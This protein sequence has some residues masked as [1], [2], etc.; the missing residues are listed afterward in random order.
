[1]KVTYSLLYSLFIL[2]VEVNLESIKNI[3]EGMKN[4]IEEVYTLPDSINQGPL[5]ITLSALKA[6]L[7]ESPNHCLQRL[8]EI[9]P[10]SAA[11]KTSTT[12]IF[13]VKC[14]TRSPRRIEW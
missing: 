10:K 7:L 12:Q 1:M 13:L 6:T 14:N 3:I 2:K 9:I 4:Q 5:K 8:N 11:S